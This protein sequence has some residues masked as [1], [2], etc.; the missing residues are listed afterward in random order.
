MKIRTLLL[1]FV[2]IFLALILIPIIAYVWRFG[3]MG[4]ASDPQ[5]WGELGDYF[6]GLL[7]PIISLASLSVLG[8]ITYLV[9]E[10]TNK[11]SKNLF[12]L[13]RRMLAYDEISKFIKP[14]NS[15]TQKMGIA[16]SMVP[17][18]EK[19]PSEQAAQHM[20]K[21]YEELKDLSSVFMEFYF[22]LFEFNA[23]YGHLFQYD[24]NSKEYKDLLTESKRVSEMMSNLVSNHKNTSKLSNDERTLTKFQSLLFPV[25][26]ELRA[27]VE[28]KL[29]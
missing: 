20:L 28:T 27:E 2:T 9:A 21:V 3:K 25:F 18:Y 23:R 17:I 26:V 24:F 4:I 19:L 22:T 5:T 13:E 11:E 8:Y 12:I 10:Q 7:N 14:L 6:G 16:I 15:F 29:D 1:V